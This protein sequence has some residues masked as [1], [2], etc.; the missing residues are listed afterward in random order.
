MGVTLAFYIFVDFKRGTC[1]KLQCK[2]D[3]TSI[4]LLATAQ[5]ELLI[6]VVHVLSNFN[7][8][9]LL[10]LHFLFDFGP[11]ERLPEVFN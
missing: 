4:T 3:N 10:L 11:P 6:L 1:E 7:S 9:Y 2:D 5:A 8:C